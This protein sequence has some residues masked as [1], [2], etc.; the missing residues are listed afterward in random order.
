VRYSAFVD[1]YFAYDFER[2]PMT[3]RA[4]TTQAAR[5]DEFN[6]NLAFVDAT[7][8]R[9]R[10]RGRVAVQVGTSVQA[11]Y[12]AEP[13]TGTV[14][15]PDVSRFIQEAFAGYR[16]ARDVWVDAGVFLAPFGSESWISSDNW[17]YTRSLIA[18]NSPYYE[19]GARVTWAAAPR[20]TTQLHVMNGWQNISEN[21]GDKT[22][23][24][25]ADFLPAD[26]VALMYD[27]S[28]GNEQADTAASL[29]RLFQEI[30]A[31]VTVNGRL[32]VSG[33]VDYGVQKAPTGRPDA[34]Y[35]W[36]VLGQW[37]LSQRTALGGR[38]EQYADPDQ[39]IVATAH[40]YG[41]RAGGASL[42][43]DVAPE[44]TLLFRTELR[45][46]SA[47]DPLFPARDAS[48]GLSKR[49]WLLV[50]SVSMRLR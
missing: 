37:R 21:N 12:A 1:T 49:D 6:V 15:G 3:D 40:P 30:G 25:R 28:F 47:A 34:W 31:R 14:S 36:A 32:A 41:L 48:A 22:V 20:L 38:L 46:L 19:A 50:A 39:V 5:H 26:R 10:V 13:R 24:F 27:V 42:N 33:T 9:S 8:T 17:T 4:F 7:L 18:E 43:V 35:G 16:V 2:P 23:A 45:G 44:P 11:N 29:P